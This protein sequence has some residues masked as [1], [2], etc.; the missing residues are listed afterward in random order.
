MAVGQGIARGQL[1]YVEVWDNKPPLLYLVYTLSHLIFGGVLWPLRIL[2]FALAG[3]AV[4]YSYIFAN[5]VLGLSQNYSNLAM[6]LVTILFSFGLETTIFNAE[7]L[8]APLLLIGTY[9]VFTSGNKIWR[10]GSG[11]LI[12]GLAILTKIPTLAEILGLWLV[13]ILLGISQ[14]EVDSDKFFL[15]FWLQLKVYFENLKNLF[16]NFVI[17]FGITL[18]LGATALFYGFINRWKEFYFATIGFSGSY[19]GEDPIPP[20][21]FGIPLKTPSGFGGVLP[22]VGLSQLQFKVFLFGLTVLLLG[23]VY[24]KGKISK[25]TL[26]VGVWVS[27]AAF[28]SLISGR[29]Y[30]HYIIQVFVPFVLFTTLIINKLRS[31]Q[32]QTGSFQ[33]RATLVIAYLLLINQ[34]TITFASGMM[35]PP[36]FSPTKY[37]WDFGKVALQQKTLADWQKD[38]NQDSFEM[39]SQLVPIITDLTGPNDKILTI[40]NLSELLVGSKRLSSYYQVVAYN[41]TESEEQVWNK[42]K[43]QTKLVIIDLK[44]DKAVGVKRQINKGLKLVRR[45]LNRYEVWVRR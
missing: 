26:L 41:W 32:A 43:D 37:W 17:V 27:L 29:N 4:R 9:Y 20:I 28:G 16:Q 34:F 5:R 21:I 39:Q 24:L 18:P 12:W 8:F 22:D 14:I 23:F 15:K 40:G 10:L 19:I 11:S 25:T 33:F 35:I 3:L 44:S 38:Y 30:P 36:Y 7:N 13:Y 31:L 6:I 2:G 45:V 1:L 42:S